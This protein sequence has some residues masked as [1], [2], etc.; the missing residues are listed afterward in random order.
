MVRQEGLP[1]Q[2]GCPE[3]GRV[4]QRPTSGHAEAKFGWREGCLLEIVKP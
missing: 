4:T 1:G 3:K 2:W